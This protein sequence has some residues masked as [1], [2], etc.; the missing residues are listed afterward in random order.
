MYQPDLNPLMDG[1]FVQTGNKRW[2][3]CQRCYK[4]FKGLVFFKINYLYCVM[5]IVYKRN[6]IKFISQEEVSLQGLEYHKILLS[7]GTSSCLLLPK[8]VVLAVKI[9]SIALNVWCNNLPC[10]SEKTMTRFSKISKTSEIF[11]G[12]VRLISNTNRAGVD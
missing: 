8:K 5:L 7:S 11:L 12:P 9:T 1:L 6:K 2:K 10:V 4:I 3:K